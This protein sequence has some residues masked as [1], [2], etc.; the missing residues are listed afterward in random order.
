MALTWMGCGNW[1]EAAFETDNIDEAHAAGGSR[2]CIWRPRSRSRSRLPR[3][4][5]G[6]LSEGTAVQCSAVQSGRGGAR[7]ALIMDA[8]VGGRR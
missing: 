1:R 5:S 6:R 7:W 3:R 8:D 4:V 2:A